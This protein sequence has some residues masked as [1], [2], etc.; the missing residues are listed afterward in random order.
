MQMD[1]PRLAIL[2]FLKR[3]DSSVDELS[4]QLGI[5]PSATRQHLALL[6]RDGLILRTSVK[7]KL[8]R[9]KIYYSLTEKAEKHFPKAYYGILKEVLTDVIERNGPEE[10]SAMMGRLGMK[11]AAMIQKKLGDDWHVQSL[12][13]LLNE[14]GC[15]AEMEEMEAKEEEEGG[16][17]LIN[18]YNCVLYEI[19]AHFGDAVCEFDIQL[20]KKLFNSPVELK[21]SIANGAR[22]CSFAVY[23]SSVPVSAVEEE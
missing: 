10:L 13:E 3:K 19:A 9:P 22:C 5:S 20:F 1:N 21:S 7:E 4:A 15:Y 8:G 18:H 17:I 14:M 2:D 23:G 11:H 6:E 16:Y 12:I